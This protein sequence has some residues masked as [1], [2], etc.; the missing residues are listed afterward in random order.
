MICHNVVTF[1]VHIFTLYT[2]WLKTTT[3]H[4]ISSDLS[5]RLK[6]K[7]LSNKILK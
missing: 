6:L 5:Y 7:C 3:Y 4:T 1:L 2:A